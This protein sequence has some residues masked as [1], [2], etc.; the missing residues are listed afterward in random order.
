M[1]TSI[2]QAALVIESDQTL[3]SK[4][5]SDR[6]RKFEG[7]IGNADQEESSQK[8]PRKFGRNRNKRFRRQG[9][10]Q[11]SSGVTSVASAPCQKEVQFLGHIDGKDGI[12]VDPA[13][14]E[15]VSRWEQPKTLTEI[16]S[17][18]R[19]AGYYRRFVKDFAKI[20][21][22][23]TKL[24][25]KNER[26]VWTE[27]YEESFQELKK[28]LVTAPVLAL[29]DE[30]GNFVIYSDASLKGLG[31]VLMQYDKVI[32]YASRHLKPHEQKYPVHDLE[33]AAIVFALKLWRKANVVANALSRKEKLNMARIADELARDLEKMEIEVRVSSEGQEQLYEITFQPA[34]M[35]KIKRCQEGVMEQELEDLTGEELCTEKDNHGL[36]RFS[37]CIWIPNVAELKNEILH[38]THNSRFSIHPGS[39][40]MY[41]DLKKHFWWLGMKKEIADW[42]WEEIAMDFLV[43]LPKTRSNHDAIWVIIDRLTKS[44][45]FLSINERYSL[46]KL[47]KIYLDEIVIK[48]GVPVSI[49]SDRDPRFNSR[50]WTKFQE[51]LGTKLNMSTAYHL[52]TDGQSER[53]IQTIED[54]LRVCA[55]DFKGNWDDHFPLIEFSYNNSYHASIGM[56]PYEALYGRKCRSPLYWDE[57]SRRPGQRRVSSPSDPGS[58][59]AADGL[60]DDED[61]SYVNIALIA[62]SDETEV[63]SSS[64]QAWK[65]S[66][67]VHAQITK[68]Q[69]IESFYDEAWKKSKEKLNPNLE[70]GLSTD[71][72]SMD[73]EGYSSNDQMN[74]PSKKKETHLSSERKPVRK[75][76][77]AKL[78]EKYGLVSK[79]FV[80][81]E[82]SLV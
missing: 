22:P 16:R 76:Q 64:N 69:G 68:V 33:L 40:K 47:V 21:T 70:E 58:S 27:K 29:P 45:H 71:V 24:T 51:C 49:V 35:E 62:K 74:Y 32:T 52:Q 38:E 7:G 18:I 41:Q 10:A 28:R 14:I 5:R 81:G 42:K 26:F 11:T 6:K 3:A 23:L 46:E 4:E 15:A 30:T 54:I 25:R 80:P 19:L 78:I 13:K 57:M 79:N 8:F 65:S 17:F 82:I 73:N 9:M 66:R 59:E 36:F 12:K 1:Y 2:V 75:S 77:L 39:T 61:T 63:S 72:N 37:S 50:F 53:T 44:G 31:C 20:S 55:L 56:P 67:D 48:H 34:L 60:E 43:G